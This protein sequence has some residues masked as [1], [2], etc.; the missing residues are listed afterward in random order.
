MKRADEVGQD[1]DE[2]AR[3]WAQQGYGLETGYSG[4]GVEREENSDAVQLP[5]DEWGDRT[6]LTSQYKA[7]ID[8]LGLP[9]PTSVVEIGAGGGRST[10]ALLDALGSD[11]GEYHVVDVAAAFVDTLR[12]RV[13]RDLDIH[14]VSDVDVSFLA[15][16]SIDLV[17]AQ[18]S[19]SA[20]RPSSRVPV[21]ARPAAGTAPGRARRGERA[22]PARGSRRL[23]V[24]PVPPQ[25]AP[26]R[27]GQLRGVPRVHLRRGDR[28]NAGAAGS[29]TWSS[30]RTPSS[31]ARGALVGKAH[32][33]S[34]GPSGIATTRTSPGGSPTGRS[35]GVRLPV[36]AVA[37]AQPTGLTRI[38]NGVA[39]RARKL[40]PHRT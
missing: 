35:P 1:F 33:K 28:R 32:R 9:S 24:E 36:P 18:S 15:D 11:A 6:A 2:Y 30:S 19:W 3:S 21:P 16:S 37:P 14:I 34:I 31:P 39:R 13:S 8:R 40:L 25:G 38:R 26:D 12:E 10:V 7:L 27:P 22:V 23:D 4:S 29:P 5:G 17:L 20:H